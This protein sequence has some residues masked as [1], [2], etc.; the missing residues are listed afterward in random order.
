V[1]VN[2]RAG[3]LVVRAGAAENTAMQMIVVNQ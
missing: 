1:A 3:R 2:R